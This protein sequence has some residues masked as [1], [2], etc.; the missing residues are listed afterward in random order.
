MVTSAPV[1]LQV[2]RWLA[3]CA[4]GGCLGP[5][6]RA[7]G[8]ALDG[9]W[10][11]WLQ[12]FGGHLCSAQRRH[13]L[14]LLPLPKQKGV[15]LGPM[16]LAAEHRCDR[17]A[18]PTARKFAQAQPFQ[19]LR[20]KP[21]P[22]SQAWTITPPLARALSFYCVPKATHPVELLLPPLHHLGGKNCPWFREDACVCT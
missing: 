4:R 3:G 10:W 8:H 9:A 17:G 11:G 20:G 2:C 7:A 6:C 13:P 18:S 15:T 19:S 1:L 14:L 22:R 12:S 5:A 16:E 21:E